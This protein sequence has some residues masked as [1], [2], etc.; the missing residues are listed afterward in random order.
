LEYHPP[1][2]NK[3]I[4]LAYA[5]LAGV[6]IGYGMESEA[7]EAAR[8]AMSIDDQLPMAHDV[9]GHILLR[10][11]YDFVGA[12]GEFKR[13]LELDPNDTSAHESYSV[14]LTTLG[15]HEEALT[16]IQ[17]AA[18]INPLSP[19]LYSSYGD[20]FFYARRYDE[21]ITQFKES[22]ELEANNIPAR[23]GL[24]QVYQMKGSYA[25]SVEERAKIAEIV[26]GR[27]A[28][29]FMREGFASGGWQGFLRAMTGNNQAP[30]A[31]PLIMA[32]FYAEL[33]EKDQALAILN[34]LYENRALGSR[35]KV[36]PRFDSLRDDS[37]FQDLLRRRI[38]PQ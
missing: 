7:R 11:D 9:L 33:G 32:A 15:R 30:K 6:Y 22:L 8:K 36:D 21:A 19:G 4:A 26:V 1:N 16:E 5:Y 10:Y 23:M 37:R 31:P 29:D 18:E 12:E 35:L 25:E 27:Q 2:R 14:L 13:A 20:T 38:F 28:A 24:A 3:R 17:Q 34:K